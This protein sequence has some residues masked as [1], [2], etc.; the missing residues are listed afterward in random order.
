MLFPVSNA[1][2]HG[3]RHDEQGRLVLIGLTWNE[4]REFERLDESLPFEGQHVWLTQDL[5]LL[6]MEARWH[7]LWTKHQA[8]AN[9]NRSEAV[10]RLVELG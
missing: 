8:A 1:P 2:P 4:T 9:A 10:P 6:P 3:Y 7:E 5:P